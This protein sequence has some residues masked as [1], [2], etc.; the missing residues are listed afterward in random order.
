MASTI[1]AFLKLVSS[2]RIAFVT[3]LLI[4]SAI[5]CQPIDAPEPYGALPSARQL[6]WHEL[7]YYAF[8]HFGPN[9]FTDVEWGHGTENPEDFNPTELDARQWARVIKEAGME[10]VIITAKHHDGFALWPSALS[11]HTVRES[12]WKNGEGDVLLELA[13]ACQEF[14]LKFGVYL[15]PWDRNHPK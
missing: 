7:R 3:G 10:G 14:G 12:A 4:F 11:T 6:D 2:M 5:G 1:T 8:I 15:S 13:K 9:T